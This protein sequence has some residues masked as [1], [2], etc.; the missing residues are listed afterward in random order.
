MGREIEITVNGRMERITEGSTIA[1]LITRYEEQDLHLIVELNGAF[2][3]SQQYATT[4]ASEGD[5]IE[6]VHPEFGG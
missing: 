4:V 5:R 1:E 6:F 2:V 3:Y